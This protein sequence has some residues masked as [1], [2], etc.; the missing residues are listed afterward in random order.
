M[1]PEVVRLLLP[2]TIVVLTAV[3]VI[4]AGAFNPATRW[5]SGCAVLGLIFAGAILMRGPGG[6]GE[7]GTMIVGPVVIDALSRLTRLLGVASGLVFVFVFTRRAERNDGGEV[8]GMLLLT[9][10]GLMLV[11]CVTNVALLFLA[12]E[13]ISI[14]TYVLLFVGRP[15][16]A[17]AESAAKY[18]LLSILSSAVFMLGVSL[19][20]GAAGSMELTSIASTLEATSG[21][22]IPRML[23]VAFLLVFVGLCFKIAAVPFQFYAPDVYGAA[24][25]A[26]AGLLAVVPKVAG[27]V[28]MM[29]LVAVMSPVW[30]G[31]GWQLA[32]IIAALTMTIGNTCA[33]WQTD[34]RRILA[35]SSIAHAGYMLI[36]LAVWMAMPDATGLFSGKVAAMLYAF[37]YC[38]ASIGAFGVL[39]VLG[40]QPG[41]NFELSRL[42]GLYRSRPLLAATLGVCMFSLAGLPPLPGFWGKF[43][44]LGGAVM[45]ARAG[46]ASS[47]WFVFLA[48]VGAI[49]AANWCSLLPANCGHNVLR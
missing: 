5:W 35:Y 12:L 7:Q 11:S 36:G 49:N 1:T 22:Q 31:F 6:F 23:L 16:N 20:Y 2:E 32:L 8:L 33:L 45:V 42:G 28:A 46:T 24:T 29:R 18:F 13:L 44:L 27:L 34:V 30:D 19:M 40:D 48:I 26:N 9:I 37:M 3:F 25:S 21:E 41:G 4:V 43:G 38:F 17:A 47:G 39:S 14:P 15:D 10:V